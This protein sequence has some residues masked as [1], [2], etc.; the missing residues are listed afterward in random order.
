MQAALLGRKVGMTQVYDEAG[1]LQPVTVVQAGPC[2]VTQ[3]KTAESDGYNAAQIGFEP[4]KAQRATQPIIGHA[5]KS[6][7]K[8][9]RKY[10][11]IRTAA[12]PD[13]QAGQELTVES[14]KDVKWVDIIGTSKGKGYAGV[15][16]RH[17]FH[18]MSA[19]HGTERMH[20]HGGS[21]ASHGNERGGSGGPKKGKRMSGR[22][23]GGQVTSRNHKLI[24]VDADNHLLLIK[25]AIPAPTADW[26][27]F[28]RAQL[29]RLRRRRHKRRFEDM[30]MLEVPVYDMQGEKIE[31]LKVDEEI[32]GG[33]INASLLKQAVVAYHTNTHQGSAAT[34]S[35]GMVVGSGRKLYKQK[36]T[37]FA[38]RGDV[39]TNLMKG[40]GVA[41]RKEP[42]RVRHELS[43][44]SRQKALESAILS[45]LVGQDLVVVQG[46]SMQAPKTK[47][48]AATLKQAGSQSRLY[49][50]AARAERRDLPQRPQ[51][52]PR[53]NPDAG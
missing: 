27:W 46:L 10:R 48:V 49:S 22:L 14:F 8:P 42:Y 15:M 38:R 18:G 28:A 7:T 47:P 3:V 52:S 25:G 37:G 21:I 34:R 26:S 4:I 32:F 2:Q 20:R 16:K 45:K 43:R 30:A 41:F 1:T 11:E 51:H 12:A 44:Q 39:R 19:S 17:N 23:G 50:D 40:G 31:T 35:R 5:A 29:R 36:G 6:S 53:G 9:M 33:V 24:G 13:V